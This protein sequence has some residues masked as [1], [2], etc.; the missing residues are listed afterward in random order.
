M[1][2]FDLFT[3]LSIDNIDIWIYI[4]RSID[5][6]NCKTP[7]YSLIFAP[8]IYLRTWAYLSTSFSTCNT[9]TKYLTL[10]S[11]EYPT[12]QTTKTFAVHEVWSESTQAVIKH[13][14]TWDD[15]IIWSTLRVVPR[16][17]CPLMHPIGAPKPGGRHLAMPARASDAHCNCSATAQTCPKLRH[18]TRATLWYAL[19]PPAIP[20]LT[21][22]KEGSLARNRSYATVSPSLLSENCKKT[23]TTKATTSI[24]HSIHHFLSFN[25]PLI[26]ILRNDAKRPPT[27]STTTVTRAHVQQGSAAATYLDHIHLG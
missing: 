24:A 2:L 15:L 6:S 8:Y 21:L 11:Y 26:R 10:I 12:H 3:E 18:T 17:I 4:T 7:N 1:Y 22:G 9:K 23:Q 14:A 5:Q 27:A 16:N 25:F 13:T 19:P 20:K